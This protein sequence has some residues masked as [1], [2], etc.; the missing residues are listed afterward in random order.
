MLIFFL[1]KLPFIREIESS[2]DFTVIENNYS[3][4]FMIRNLVTN[5]QSAA[6]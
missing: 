1:K 2:M 3:I 5:N 4:L 6:F